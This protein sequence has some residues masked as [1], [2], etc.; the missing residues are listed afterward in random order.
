MMKNEYDFFL[1]DKEHLKGKN[2]FPFQLYIF[3]PA[4]KNY[5]LFLNGNRPITKEHNE[6]LDYILERGGKIAIL[7]NQRKTFLVAQEMDASEVPSLKEREL[8]PLEKERIMNLKLKEM[9][10]EK[11]GAFSL[12]SA[13]EKACY[14][15]NFA[16]IIEEVRMDVLTFSVTA[17]PTIS[18]AIHLVKNHLEADNYTNRIVATSYLLAKNTDILD[19]D[20]LSD[21]ICGAYFSHVGLTQL[22]LTITRTPYRNLPEKERNLFQ[23]HTILGQHLIKKSQIDLSERAKKIILDHHERS[24]GN[25]Y[26]AMKYGDQ[27]DTLSQI[28]GAVSHLFEYTTGRM[29]GRQSTMKATLKSMAAKSYLPGLEFD[30]GEKV[31]QSIITLINTDTIET[32]KEEKTEIN[33]AA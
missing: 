26:P 10:E 16:Q 20:A 29:T 9:Y 12:Q 17:S 5:S 28:V 11:R 23:K 32:K 6:F 3:N 25:G 19:Q 7:K 1:I 33:K 31:F 27:I 8:H 24:T 14:D 2:T 30:F 18:L 13:F 22:P 4:H 21:I 15:N